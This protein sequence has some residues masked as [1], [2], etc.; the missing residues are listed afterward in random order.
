MTAPIAI[1]MG[2]QSDWDTMRHAAETLTAL[3]I[4]CEKHIVSAHRTPDRMF[5]FAKGAKAAGFQIIIA[6]AGGAAHLPG[7]AASL[8][9]LPV[10]GVPIESRALSGVDSLYS[11]VQMPAGVPVGTL[12][13]GKPGAINAALLAASVL[14]LNDSALA[15]RLAAWRKQQTE[16]VSDRPEGSA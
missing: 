7:M 6:G 11:I 16:A 9:E 5:A 1:I 10:F 14:A 15:G 12:A 3:G 2:S 4:A 13:I 8:T